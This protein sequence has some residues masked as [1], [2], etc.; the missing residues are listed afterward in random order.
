VG[1]KFTVEPLKSPRTCILVK[2]GFQILLFMK[3]C[4]RDL[5]AMKIKSSSEEGPKVITLGSAY[6]P[7]DDAEPQPTRELDGLVTECRTEG[8]HLIIGCDANSHNT[9]WVVQIST[10]EVSPYLTTLWLMDWT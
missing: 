3:H 4:S 6:F 1:N 8:T 7:Y 5:T 2:E 10:I 9:S